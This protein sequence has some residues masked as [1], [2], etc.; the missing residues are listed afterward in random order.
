LESGGRTAFTLTL[1]RAEPAG[2][3]TRID[4]ESYSYLEGVPMATPLGMDLA[5]GF[6]DPADVHLELGTGPIADELRSLGLPRLPDMCA[7]G[8]GLTATFQ[9]G[10]P[11]G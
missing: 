1:P 9:L 2:A 6:V 5:T 7:W 4:T 8:E 3:A 11:I 10:H